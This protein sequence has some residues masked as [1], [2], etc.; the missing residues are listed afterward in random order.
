[1][2]RLLS[3][4]QVDA[5]N[6]QL[7]EQ[8]VCC[9]CAEMPVTEEEDGCYFGPGLSAAMDALVAQGK[10]HL[11]QIFFVSCEVLFSAW[12]AYTACL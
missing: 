11:P 10:H 3:V 1:M 7:L 9:A 4:A 6:P 12:C 8:H 5:N 2:V